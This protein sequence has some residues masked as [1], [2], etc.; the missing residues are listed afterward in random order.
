[1]SAHI[2]ES[3]SVVPERSLQSHLEKNNTR[4]HQL[5]SKERA[6]WSALMFM[7][8]T[9]P[10]TGVAE[11]Q[12]TMK[13]STKHGTPT[14]NAPDR[15]DGKTLRY[16]PGYYYRKDTLD[17][18]LSPELQKMMEGSPTPS[19]S[20]ITYESAPRND[21]PVLTVY[22]TD[23]GNAVVRRLADYWR[24]P[25]QTKKMDD[26]ESKNITEK[27]PALEGDVTESRGSCF[28][29]DGKWGSHIFT[30]WHV[31]VNMHQNMEEQ[32]SFLFRSDIVTMPVDSVITKNG[33]KYLPRMRLAADPSV[34]NKTL[35]ALTVELHGFGEEIYTVQ[36]KPAPFPMR[37]GKYG[38][39]E[40]AP[41][42]S[43]LIDGTK[44]KERY[45][46]RGTSGSA[47]TIKNTGEVVGIGHSASMV[48]GTMHFIFSGI[49]DLRTAHAIAE[50]Q[51]HVRYAMKQQWPDTF[52]V[53]P[54]YFPTSQR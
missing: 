43:L 24:N 38:E 44:I 50:R 21:S 47:I 9:L 34:N 18:V 30:V 1:M 5:S 11:G 37:Y 28:C 3:E 35:P 8:A 41:M 26:E 36:G 48:D 46:F 22:V 52:A 25:D 39:F 12:E 33:S 15:E 16:L 20:T 40:S 29:I 51:Q 10:A 19:L 17:Y 27:K 49:N 6:R 4:V 23:Q 13:N 7:I 31:G 42:F 45:Q 54:S 14:E 2:P 53:P 32:M